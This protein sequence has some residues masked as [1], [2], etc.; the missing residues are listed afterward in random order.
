MRI[1]YYKLLL[2]LLAFS[3]LVFMMLLSGC[4]Q[5][6]GLQQD[7]IECKAHAGRVQARG[8]GNYDAELTM[9]MWDRGYKRSKVSTWVPIKECDHFTKECDHWPTEEATNH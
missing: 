1:E 2:Y 5:E 6:P 8:H 3:G 7:L 9:C 4:A